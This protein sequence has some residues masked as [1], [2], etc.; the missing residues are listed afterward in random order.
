VAAGLLTATSFHAFADAQADAAAEMARKAQDPLG[1]EKAIMSD[2]TIGLKGGSDEDAAYG[3]QIQ[4]V[5]SLG[6]EG[7]NNHT[8]R[9]VIP[10]VGVDPG[11]VISRLG[12]EPRSEAGDNFGFSDIMLQYIISPKSEG[13]IK[14]GIGPQ[15]SLK[16]RSSDRQAGLGRRTGG[17]Y[18]WWCRKLGLRHGGIPALGRRQL[19]PAFR[20]AYHYV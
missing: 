17:R 7:K 6:G 19:Q 20:A 4:P 8:L 9:A 11:V 3:F 1:D 14:W 13:G 18:I 2:N 12:E 16:S 15:G 10:L 5:Y